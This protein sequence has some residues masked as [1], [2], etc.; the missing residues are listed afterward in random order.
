M[1]KQSAK[2]LAAL[3]VLSILTG[4]SNDKTLGEQSALTETEST[5]EQTGFS[6]L[7]FP[8]TIDGHDILVG[9]TTIQELL[10]DG[11]QLMVSEWKDEGVVQYAIDP[12][13]E[14]KAGSENKEISFWITDNAFARVSIA[15]RT[16][17]M[18]VGETPITRFALHLSHNA[19]TLPEHILIDG[20]PVTELTRKKAW[21][22]FPDFE[23]ED[24]SVTQRDSDLICSLMFS[25][26]TLALYQ[27]SLRETYGEEPELEIKVPSI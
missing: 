15:A 19:D 21:E 24:L 22:M 16:N 14:L 5:A 13:A 25:P 18:I 4:C 23:Q 8:V 10:D 1:R 7:R 11:F 3:M 20:V 27:F 12:A 2:G 9:E 17:D 26:R 6:Q